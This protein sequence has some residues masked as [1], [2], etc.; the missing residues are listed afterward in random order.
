MARTIDLYV[1]REPKNIGLTINDSVGLID[2]S[3]LTYTPGGGGGGFPA[4]AG[5]TRYGFAAVN[6]SGE[7]KSAAFD[8]ISPM[9]GAPQN[10][11]Y[12]WSDTTLSWAALTSSMGTRLLGMDFIV[13]SNKMSPKQILAGTYDSQFIN[14]AEGAT[15]AVILI[16]PPHEIDVKNPSGSNHATWGTPAQFIS[17][18]QRI[19]GLVRT[20]GNPLVKTAIG[21]GYQSF[22]SRWPFYFVGPDDVDFIGFDPY[23][24]N[25]RIGASMTTYAQGYDQIDYV[26]NWM[27]DRWGVADSRRFLI[28]ENSYASGDGT[29]PGN[30]TDAQAAAVL[31]GQ[32]T[33]AEDHKLFAVQYFHNQNAPFSSTSYLMVDGTTTGPAK[34]LTRAQWTAHS[35]L[36]LPP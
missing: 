32:W 30:P 20:V 17:S 36:V 19:T 12:Y 2:T 3:A 6:K 33:A 7:S 10:Y 8:R 26:L 21:L 29:N 13:V 14:F 34:P 18:A 11:R 5:V 4:Y 35:G 15:Q 25:Y 1:G 28:N 22:E 9:I 31:N 16:C 24:Y 27:E 23:R